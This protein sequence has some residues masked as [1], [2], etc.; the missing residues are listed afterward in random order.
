MSEKDEVD[1]VT[2][3]QR[4]E[5][6]E[7]GGVVTP[8][9][10]TS[11][12]RGIDSS[13]AK[14]TTPRAPTKSHWVKFDDPDEADRKPEDTSPHPLAPP[15]RPA[16]VLTT[17]TVHVNVSTSSSPTRS[18][19]PEMN[20]QSGKQPS[21]AVIEVPSTRSGGDSGGGMRTIELS[22]GRIRE[23]FAN[24]DIIV[25]LLPVNTKW[26]WV[27]P[28]IFRPELVPE[29]LMAQGLTL[30]VE[31]YVH[32]METLVNDYRFTLYNVCY[33][34]VLVCWILF[35]FAV[36]LGLLFS[37]LTGI[38]LFVLGVAWLFL[39]AAAIFLCMWIKLKLS[40][41]LEKCL[42]LVNKQLLRHKILLALDDRGKI[43]CHKVNLCFLYFDSSQC[44][45]YLNDFIA[46]H[47]QSG[48]A[49]PR[50][51]ESRMDLGAADIVIQGST[52]TRVS[53]K[54]TVGEEL[55]L[56][57]LQRWGKDFLRRRLDWILEEN[58]LSGSPRHLQVAICPCQYAEEIVLNKPR[59]DPRQCCACIT[60]WFTSR[61]INCC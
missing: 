54:Q 44:V 18:S 19:G 15:P 8:D 58:G 50:G 21:V 38:T 20:H 40:R 46:R 36:L 2:K 35:A 4:T 31:E 32:A 39:N 25:T 28:A 51:W 49:V 60:N 23:G 10:I 29:E 3:E 52:T 47:E 30:T 33:K 61:G 56:R 22:T 26:P 55:F 11:S 14:D 45:S 24:G 6:A 13:E 34:R 42:A 37:G 53:R 59:K 41:G 7:N 17:E 43:S 48:D 12:A 57:Y 9:V 1:R 5:T 16:A 27:T